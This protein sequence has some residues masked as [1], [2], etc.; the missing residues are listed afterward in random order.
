[1][2]LGLERLYSIQGDHTR[3]N[4]RSVYKIEE[5]EREQ[6]HGRGKP[7]PSGVV[8]VGWLGKQV[9]FLQRLY[10]CLPLLIAFFYY[11]LF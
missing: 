1:M 9:P 8:A 2:C 6:D 10:H 3:S 11:L 4:K 7:E 5:V